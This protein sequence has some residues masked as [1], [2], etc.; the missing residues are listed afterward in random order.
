MELLESED[1][2]LFYRLCLDII[3]SAKHCPDEKAALSTVIRRTWRWHGLLKGGWDER[4]GPEGQKGLIGEMRVLELALLEVFDPADALE[5]W[6]GPEGAPKDFSIGSAAIEAKAR[7]GSARPHIVISSEHQLEPGNLGFLFLAV[8]EIDEGSADDNGAWTL[9]QCIQRLAAMIEA[10]DAGAAGFFESRLHQA[11]YN[12]A[13]DYSDRHWVVGKTRWF[14]VIEGFPSISSSDL[15][16]GVRDV[17]YSLDLGSCTDY[18]ADIAVVIE[19]LKKE[20]V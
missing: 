14:S 16:M 13:H 15:V 9:T 2:D 12:A 19:A 20:R 4:L 10:R 18:E 7:R 8:T 5:F 6:R 3:D 17:R 11:G 1:R